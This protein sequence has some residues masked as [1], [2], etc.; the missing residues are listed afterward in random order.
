MPL[1][2]RVDADTRAA[3]S[4]I[5]S[6]SK[7]ASA[8][9][10][11][12][13]TKS[14][15]SA[16]KIQGAFSN[17]GIVLGGTAVL[18]GIKAIIKATSDLE[19]S[20]N[21]VTVV[22]KDGADIILDFGKTAAESVGL[23][24][25]EF[26]QLAT[27][28]GALL[29]GTGIPLAEV[30][31]LTITLTKRAADMASVFNK[32]VKQALSA[33]NQAIRGET[34]AIRI[35]SGD[36]TDASLQTFLFSKGINT[37]VSS[38]TQEEKRLLRVDLLLAQT[39]VTAGDFG[40]TQ[41]SLANATRI[42][43]ARMLDLAA[44]IGEG[45]LP[46]AENAVG[47]LG[48]LIDAIEKINQFSDKFLTGFGGLIDKEIVEPTK[49]GNEATKEFLD[50]IKM[51]DAA[52]EQSLVVAGLRAAALNDVTENLLK[53]TEANEFTDFIDGIGRS[54]EDDILS[55][56]EET[57]SAIDNIGDASERW[58]KNQAALAKTI[59]E[60][61]KNIKIVDKSMELA[62]SAAENFSQ[63]LARALISGKGLQESLLGAAINLGLSFIP[64][65]SLFGGLFA[66]GG[67]A[68]GG[69]IPSIVGEAGGAPEII[70]SATPIRVT[71][72][73]TTNNNNFQNHFTLVFP[74]VRELDDF[75]LQTNIIPKINALVKGGESPLSA[76]EIV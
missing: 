20:V 22:F 70:Q 43:G 13:E 52:Q 73:T 25:A 71:P 49:R 33:I 61:P 32:D 46:A 28:T 75:E 55:P 1:I 60:L 74:A 7:S 67:T 4:K 24:N 62:A 40:N 39:A 65:G 64:G 17:I 36:V 42:L 56:M 45:L 8:S 35:F 31:N 41:D 30:S 6:A 12:L 76:S 38:L 18:G 48:K 50:L 69:G 66:H 72:L 29:V 53:L 34:E 47:G 5:K 44:N 14:V 16:S 15:S 57:I 11:Q 2:L 3:I 23:A 19:E 68:P 63:S 10:K 37:L 59:P 27:E 21:A 58:A 26:N 54:F 9:I 51:V